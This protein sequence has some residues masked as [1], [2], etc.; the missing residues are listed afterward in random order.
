MGTR[1]M[2]TSAVFK[3]HYIL[4]ISTLLTALCLTGCANTPK[5]KHPELRLVDYVDPEKFE[6]EWFIIA[7]IP[8]FAEKNK[9]A[10]KSIYK[11]RL[12]AKKSNQQFI[13]DDIYVYRKKNFDNP[14]KRVKGRIKSLNNSHN[15]WKSTFF[16]LINFTF[17]VIYVD[18]NYSMMLFGH[19]SRKY[20]WVMSPTPTLSDEQYNQAMSIFERNNYDINDFLKIPQK[21]SQISEK[22]FQ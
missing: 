16:G 13:Y 17:E 21:K 6:G 9:I 10:T 1:P 8:Y 2:P 12:N 19:P 15:R 22:A 3:T 5:H 18:E 11:K 20:G 14:S 7:N 4:L